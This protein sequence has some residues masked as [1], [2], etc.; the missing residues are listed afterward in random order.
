MRCK[1]YKIYVTVEETKKLFSEAEK[2]IYIASSNGP[3]A[4]VV[5]DACHHVYFGPNEVRSFAATVNKYDH[6]VYDRDFESLRDF[7]LYLANAGIYIASFHWLEPHNITE[8]N[9]FYRIKEQLPP[10]GG[11]V[12]LYRGELYTALA[13]DADAVFFANVDTDTMI[14]YYARV[15]EAFVNHFRRV[16]PDLLMG[17][18]MYGLF[19]IR[20]TLRGILW[21]KH[22]ND[23]KVITT[24]QRLYNMLDDVI[25]V[26]ELASL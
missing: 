2:I 6:I 26:I 8:L 18:R 11:V 23:E 5:E 1:E 12:R 7:E 22:V 14:A 16:T 21:N 17:R 3:N 20:Y 15:A 13:V 24:A 19:G 25:A 4:V 9:M 10:R